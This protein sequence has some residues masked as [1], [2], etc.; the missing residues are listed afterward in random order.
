MLPPVDGVDAETA[1][2][3]VREV[4]RVWQWERTWGWDYPWTAMAAAR[5]GE[6]KLAVDSLLMNTPKNVYDWRG[7]NEGGPCPYLPGN[8]G[9]L[10]AAA[11]MA[12]AG[13]AHRIG[14]LPDSRTT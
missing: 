5:V 12:S 13:T 1:H 14:M 8:G 4:V 7:V 3:T 10:Y 11:M 2:R 6:P 9:L